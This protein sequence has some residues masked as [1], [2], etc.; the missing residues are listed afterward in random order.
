M[1]TGS[2]SVADRE[3]ALAHGVAVDLMTK[4]PTVAQGVEL[5]ERYGLEVSPPAAG[6]DTSTSKEGGIDDEQAESTGDAG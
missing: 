1:Y 4:P 3:H 6:G 2:H 5:A